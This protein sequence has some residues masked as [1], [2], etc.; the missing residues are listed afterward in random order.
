MARIS[1]CSFSITS[2]K[3]EFFTSLEWADIALENFPQISRIINHLGWGR[4]QLLSVI[5]WEPEAS[6]NKII[7]LKIHFFKPIES[8]SI[9][10]WDEINYLAQ[11]CSFEFPLPLY[12]RDAFQFLKCIFCWTGCVKMHD[13]LY[14]KC[15]RQGTLMV[16]M[17]ASSWTKCV[18]LTTPLKW[19][20][21]INF[22]YV[23]KATRG[24]HWGTATRRHFK[25][26]ILFF[27]YNMCLNTKLV[28]NFCFLPAF[29]II[30][31]VSLLS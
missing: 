25:W 16:A 29:S 20:S 12:A 15:Y 31:Y 26:L 7:K 13:L 2:V 14:F 8:I 5:I 28:K 30:Y 6:V 3:L 23:G 21:C 18:I 10:V 9:I 11:S 22:H 19:G 4:G 17:T 27:F 24:M 1:T